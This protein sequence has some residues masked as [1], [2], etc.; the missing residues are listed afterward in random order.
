[1]IWTRLGERISNNFSES[2][3]SF[4]L[5]SYRIFPYF[6]E[7]LNIE[8]HYYYYYY[9]CACSRCLSSVCALST[10]FCHPF[11]ARASFSSW[12]SSLSVVSLVGSVRVHAGALRDAAAATSWM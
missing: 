2:K 8:A 12:C 3:N 11:L 9:Y 5:K 7:E 10:S 4:A 1:M 6:T